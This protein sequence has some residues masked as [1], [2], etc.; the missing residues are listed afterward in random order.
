VVYL[1]TLSLAQSVSLYCQIVESLANYELNKI[2]KKAFLAKFVILTRYLYR[3]SE[4]TTKNLSQ[5][6]C[7]QAETGT[8][9]LSYAKQ[10][11]YLT[12]KL[13]L[14]SD[15]FHSRYIFVYDRYFSNN[16]FIKLGDL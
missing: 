12:A 4:K 6:T 16:T 11:C 1:T 9:K 15:I 7:L 13:V 14:C 10:N 5:Y 2:W 8:W 3:Q